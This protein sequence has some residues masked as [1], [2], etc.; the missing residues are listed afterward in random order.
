MCARVR[1]QSAC[2]HR[3]F[4]IILLAFSAVH[5]FSLPLSSFCP[6]SL[7]STCYSRRNTSFIW[8][9]SMRT[10]STAIESH[11]N[12]DFQAN[13][14][15]RESDGFYHSFRW[16]HQFK[17]KYRNYLAGKVN[18]KDRAIITFYL[19]FSLC[20]RC[21]HVCCHCNNRLPHK[22]SATIQNKTRIAPSSQ[23]SSLTYL[24]E[25][26]VLYPK[27]IKWWINAMLE[28]K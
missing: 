19:C 13:A 7:V 6:H 22:K 3:I 23:N 18:N 4:F 26:H 20:R 10:C 5:P 11:K 8:S 24:V 16:W 25:Y 15:E 17:K 14:C 27:R 28:L 9:P 1:V 12:F 21:L 2:S